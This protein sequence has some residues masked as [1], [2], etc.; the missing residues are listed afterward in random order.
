[1]KLA[2]MQPY[3][4]PY[5]GMFD[6]LNQVDVWIAYDPGQYIR[7]GWVNRNRV[8][9]PVAGWQYI[10]LPLQQ[11]SHSAAI[12]ALYIS[13]ENWKG[14][15]FKRLDHYHM[16]APYYHQVI[17]FLQDGLSSGETNLARL[18]VALFRATA[19]RLGIS[20]PIY[21][22]SEMGISLGAARGP[23]DLA[24]AITQA[25]HASEYVNPPGGK[26]MYSPS[27]FSANGL[28]L[29]IQSFTPMMYS[30]GRFQFEPNLSII[31]LMMWNSPEQIKHYLDT[32][33]LSVLPGYDELMLAYSHRS[34]LH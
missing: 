11:H 21:V 1:M 31:D 33:R 5:L 15:I 27:K 22:F 26:C 29:T 12:N 8:L 19:R 25:M 32:F 14:E 20:T 9:H 13:G 24:L 2:A 10:T 34:T 17:H 4:F 3:F 6:L 16:D 30:C 18:N 7:H 23:E 28:K